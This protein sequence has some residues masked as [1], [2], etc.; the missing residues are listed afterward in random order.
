[1]TQEKQPQPEPVQQQNTQWLVISDLDGTLLDHY[2]Y[3]HVDADT[4]LQ[5]LERH[6]TPVIFNSSKTRE[7]MLELRESFGNRHP[8]IVENGSAI[9]IPVGYFPQKPRNAVEQDNYW[10]LE[11]GAARQQLLDFLAHDQLQHPATYLNFHAATT[12]EIVSATGLSSSQAHQAQSRAYSEPLLWQGN[13]Q[14]K[15]AFIARANAAGFATLQGGR[16][17]H[18]LGQTDK[19][20]ATQLLAKTYRQYSDREVKLIASGD[21]PNDL[22]MLKV[23]DVA[24]IVR[25]PVHAPPTLPNHRHLIVTREL[26]PQGWAEAIREVLPRIF[27]STQPEG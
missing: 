16:F 22:D 15:E 3:S 1:M 18:L 14:Q 5:Q 6:G 2:S 26:G 7:E 11:P 17:L 25:S 4:T 9:F 19:G 12:E 27:H 20:Q 13:E 24:I 8:F 21:G 10:V 23:A